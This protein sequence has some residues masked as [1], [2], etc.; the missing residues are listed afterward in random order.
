[1]L[2]WQTLRRIFCLV[3]L[4]SF[5]VIPSVASATPS[6]SM[7]TTPLERTAQEAGQLNS[8]SCSSSSS[9]MA[10]GNFST[11]SNRST[12][13]TEFWNGTIWKPESILPPAG[14]HAAEV[15]L[16]G[17]SCSS[18]TN[19]AVVG[20]YNREV[21]KQAL[22]ETRTT[23][24]WVQATTSLPPE[25]VAAVLRSVSCI[26]NTCMAVGYYETTEHVVLPLAEEG[27]IGSN[28]WTVRPAINPGGP[29]T[30]L[31]GIS[32]LKVGECMA[33]GSY[34]HESKSFTL[35]EAWNGTTWSLW[36]TPNRTG[37][38][39]FYGSSLDS[40]S[41]DPAPLSCAATGV[42]INAS[43][44]NFAIADK[45]KGGTG[46][47]WS[48]QSIPKPAGATE[49]RL[50]SVSCYGG[51]C[52]A[53]GVY[54][55][56]SG[57]APMAA[58]GV[59]T[60][61]STSWEL[62]YP[63]IPPSS[64]GSFLTGISCTAARTCVASGKYEDYAGKLDTLSEKGAR[65]WSFMPASSNLVGYLEGLSCPSSTNCVAAGSYI[66]SL[67]NI[68]Y[69]SL[70]ERWNGTEWL[71]Q[72]IPNPTGRNYYLA[73]VSCAST[74]A[75]TVVGYYEP[76]SGPNTPYAERLNGT[77]WT[78][79]PIPS[80][81]GSTLTDLY[82]VSCISTTECIAIG[83]Y[84]NSSGV[85]LALAER[86]NGS[87]WSL[88]TIPNPTGTKATILTNIKCTSSTMCIAVGTYE[89]SS[90]TMVPLVET[91]NGAEW[92]IGSISAPTGATYASLSGLS[93]TS[94]TACTAVGTYIVSTLKSWAERW[95]GTTWSMQPA[96]TMGESSHLTSVSCTS[97]SACNAIGIFDNSLG[98]ELNLSENW[99]GVEWVTQSMPSQPGGTNFMRN[100]SCSSSTACMA[101]GDA[102]RSPV[103]E[104]YH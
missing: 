56:S 24:G 83:L 4:I 31:Q 103:A 28:V 79:Q 54:K 49:T 11:P 47:S 19:C 63:E 84:R 22:I 70:L 51:I 13:P 16:E 33:V 2:L 75:C 26:S 96:P 65:G 73:G 86:W 74:T 39:A 78:I 72:S 9:C 10:V 59:M 89:N 21:P 18:A 53:V 99:N 42:E 35:A 25:T 82:E 1:M 15:F 38:G 95:N 62:E 32:C 80:P 43:S 92:V 52:D 37:S 68:G 55:N 20:R 77:E 67:G 60:E 45:W 8:V 57:E 76:N 94:S 91:W 46:A 7:Q 50:E 12:G 101:V 81:A 36:S 5:T 17:V 98:E 34:T 102:N 88:M 64:K 93:C 85:D 40:V 6:W 66:A 41:C 3:V 100:I 87:S 29:F 97:A 61:G 14:G 30:I 27:Y 23:S 44:K 71:L 69:K 104:I 90:G 58:E 48:E